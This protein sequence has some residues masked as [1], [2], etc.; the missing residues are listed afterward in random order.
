MNPLKSFHILPVLCLLA[1]SFSPARA[2]S[3]GQTKAAAKAQG[4]P[5]RAET[6]A[7]SLPASDNIL[8]QFPASTT[9]AVEPSTSIMQASDGNFYGGTAGGGAYGYGTLYQLTPFGKYTLLYSFTGGNDGKGPYNAPIEASDGNLY[10]VTNYYGAYGTFQTGGTIYQYNLKTGALTTVY[11]FQYGG[12]AGFGELIDDGKGTIYGTANIDDPTGNN[13]GSVWSFNYLTQTFTTLHSF[14]G[15]DGN[16]PVGGLVLASD[17]NLYGTAEF[18]GPYTAGSQQN[19][20]YGTA[21]VIG[22]DGSNFHVFHNFDN[23]GQGVEDGLW[24]TSS[25]IQGPDGNLYGFTF[26]GGTLGNQ[27]GLFYQIVPN[28]VN[29]TFRS[30]YDFQAGD[31][32]NPLH[33]R[34]FLG[35]DGN[36]YIAGSNGGAHSSGQV[37]QLSPSGTKADVYDIGTN[38]ADGFTVDTQ[39]FESTDGNLYDVATFGGATNQGNIFQI[40]TTLPPVITLTPSAAVVNP[41]DS[42]TLTWAVTNAFSINAKACFAYSSDGSWTGAVPTTGNATVKPTLALGIMTYSFTCGG[43]ETAT[44]TIVVGT[45]PP[46][47]TT[48]NLPGGMVRAAYAQTLGLLGGTSP[49]TWSITAG[50]LPSGLVLS[51]STGVISGTPTQSGTSSFTVQVK[52]SE[53]TPLTATAALSIVVVPAPLVP[54][55]VAV[56]ASPSSIVLGKSTSLTATVTGLANVPTP[57]GTV[58]FAASGSALGAPVQLSNGTATLPGQAPTATGSYGITATYSGDINYTAGNVATTTLTVTAPTLAAIVATPDTVMISS[59]GGNGS[60]MLKVLNFPDASVSFA[61]SGLP[62][63]AACSFGAL[64]SSS[65]S[66]LQITTTGG[67]S[68]SLV[69]PAN[70]MGTRLMYALTLPGLFAVAGLFGRRKG[71]LRWHKMLMLAVLFC[72]GGLMTA[73]SGGSGSSVIVN[74]ATPSGTST[75]IVTATDGSQSAALNLTI[76]VQ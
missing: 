30:L 11:S 22:A 12:D 57:T 76:V 75:V 18:G 40:L 2:Q 14:T 58:Q 9:V 68:A 17:G 35:G 71:Y 27:S 29:S 72:M 70:G 28:G 7:A 63:G 64:S 50:S 56:S 3:A 16:S 36:F 31:G 20:G 53:S 73:C 61:C 15:A 55:T 45:I 59:A 10:G 13:L 6:N 1:L 47:I 26:Q 24:P 21:F 25:L 62:K 49:Y 41:G 5:A 44:A 74:N 39:P 67:G 38:P 60:T 4:T 69:Q 32:N 66:A 34:P 51:A 23:G 8:Y 54:P 52:D 19:F 65:T 42:L 33:G 48:T 46:Q 37:M 43:N